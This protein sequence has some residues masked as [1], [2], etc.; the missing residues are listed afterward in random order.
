MGDVFL[1]PFYAWIVGDLGLPVK[2][3]YFAP[4]I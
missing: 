1:S 2:K 3:G 4:K